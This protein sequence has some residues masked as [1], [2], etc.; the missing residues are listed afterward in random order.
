MFTRGYWKWPLAIDNCWTYPCG[1]WHGKWLISSDSSCLA[2]CAKMLPSGSL[3]TELPH[4]AEH[5]FLWCALSAAALNWCS[6]MLI[7]SSKGVGQRKQFKT[8]QNLSKSTTY[9]L[10][11]CDKYGVP[12]FWEAKWGLKRMVSTISL[13]SALDKN[14]GPGLERDQSHFGLWWYHRRPWHAISTSWETS[15]NCVGQ[16]CENMIE[17]DGEIRLGYFGNMGKSV[18]EFWDEP[19]NI[20]GGM[21]C[22][23]PFPKWCGYRSKPWHSLFTAKQKSCFQLWCSTH[24]HISILGIFDAHKSKCFMVKANVW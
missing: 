2:K 22:Q 10:K 16:F 11:K 7:V 14:L 1:K 12:S 17:Y 18:S 13:T 21:T 24:P 23:Q 15:E 19:M 20:A 5:L 8:G 3:T 9:I 6:W 4:G